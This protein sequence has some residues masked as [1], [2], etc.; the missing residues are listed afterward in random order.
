MKRKIVALFLSLSILLS[1]CSLTAFAADSSI[2]VAG[3]EMASGT[4]LA[5]GA[6]VTQTTQPNGGY[7]YYANGE[8]TLC[9]YSY[10]GTGLYDGTWDDY[11]GIYADGDLTIRVIGSNSLQITTADGKLTYGIA[12]GTLRFLGDIASRLDISAQYAGINTLSDTPTMTVD[13]GQI[14]A[15]GDYW[16]AVA[17]VVV[18]Q[19]TLVLKNRDT[20]DQMYDD[21]TPYYAL[22][23][24]LTIGAAVVANGSQNP[25]GTVV[26]TYNSEYHSLYDC[27]RILP[28]NMY[29]GGVS[30]ANGRYLA[31]GAS[32]SQ[33]SKPSGGYAY[34]N[35][36]ELLFQDYSYTGEGYYDSYWGDYNGIYSDY[37]LNIHL[38]GEN[39]VEIT[40]PADADSYGLVAANMVILGESG[41]SLYVS[42]SFAGIYTL[43][44]DAAT[45]CVKDGSVTA[46]G[47]LWGVVADVTVEAGELI[48]QNTDTG[49][50][51]LEEGLPYS[52]IYGS[53]TAA[54]HLKITAS[55]D[56]D[57]S[58]TVDYVEADQDSYDYIRI[59]DSAP[60]VDENI[61]IYHTLD[62]AS[63]ISVT[64]AVAKSALANYDSYYLE[65]VL[66][67]YSGNTLVGTSTVEIQ[68]VVS[69]N[70]YYFTLTGITAVRMGDMVDAVLHMTKDG[71][72]YYSKTDS[73]SV[74]TY[75]YGMLNS[76]KDAKMLTLC[77]DL[78]RYG[79]EAQSFKGY[80]TDALV[81]ADMTE[82]HR[83]YLSNTADLT[84]TATDSFLGDL[85]SP[86]ITWVGKTLDLGSKVGMKFVFNTKNY[87]GNIADLSMKVTYQG[88]NGETKTVILTGAEVYN[89]ANKQYSFTFYG[90]LASELRTIVD[91]AI[92]EG[93]TQLSE[94][95]RYSA[96]S[97]AIKTT[98]T[99]VESLTRAL[100]AYSDSAKAYFAK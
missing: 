39:R 55:Q 18:N 60:I 10:S 31:T 61:K 77:A 83:S 90:L 33:T 5:V 15:T 43:S 47:E 50:L 96:E 32:A 29:V 86:S 27:I 66:P 93:D 14:I 51:E 49:D 64:F 95:L 58:Q 23:G 40:A 7:A 75:A 53:V 70:Y 11:T 19:G 76:T 80:R 97:Y 3:V 12:A 63:D 84:F 98:N 24:T 54:E 85:A 89:A 42:A 88:G 100:F 28:R 16:G 25:A 44:E 37:S 26:A 62:L 56:P 41:A 30:L 87:S 59:A 68:P 71:Q 38:R 8:L 21:T 65:C 1:L 92:C 9:N 81:D 6:S 45:L 91:V 13:G 67:E 48:A 22:Y 72:E 73:Y 57:G 35:N 34:Y 4:Y 94:T 69:G 74:A 20:E 52:A 36:G 17:D 79:A 2:Y 46:V 99:N 78:L 82:T